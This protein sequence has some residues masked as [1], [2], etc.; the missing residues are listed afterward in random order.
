MKKSDLIQ[1]VFTPEENEVLVQS[2]TGLENIASRIAPNLSSEDRQNMGSI[3]DKNKLFVNKSQTLMEQNARLIPSFIDFEE[4]QRDFQARK[5][6]EEILLRMDAIYRQ[7]S[8]TKILLDHDN[9]QDSL[10]FYRSVRYFAQEQQEFAI[11][12]YDEL[13]KYFPGRK[14]DNGSDEAA[15]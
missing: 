14:S 13:K 5:K 7:L 15:E 11:P 2:L 6:I 1:V 12:V 4:F 3:N 9:Y 10:T 8:D